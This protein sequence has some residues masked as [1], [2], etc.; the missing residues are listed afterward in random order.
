[1]IHGCVDSTDGCCSFYHTHPLHYTPLGELSSDLSVKKSHVLWSTCF[2]FTSLT[3]YCESCNGSN[4]SIKL[5]LGGLKYTLKPVS[6]VFI[7]LQV[8]HFP[9]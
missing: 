8:M 1:M 3:G 4:F 7:R 2:C 5:A 6:N 9:N